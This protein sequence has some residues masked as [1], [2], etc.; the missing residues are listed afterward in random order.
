MFPQFQFTSPLVDRF[1]YVVYG[2]T[3]YADRADNGLKKKHLLQALVCLF[4][5]NSKNWLRIIKS[6]INETFNSQK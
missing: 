6:Q 5:V 2:C 4:F 1:K 3:N